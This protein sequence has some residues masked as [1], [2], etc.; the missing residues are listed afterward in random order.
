MQAMSA[1][2]AQ[3]M[4]AGKPERAKKALHIGIGVSEIF[5]VCMFILT[6]TGGRTLCSIFTGRMEVAQAGAD[7]LKAYAIDCLLTS[8]LFCYIGYFDGLEKTHFV[9]IQGLVGAFLIRIPVAFVMSRILP[10]SLFR[11][12]LATPCSSMVQILLCMLYMRQLKEKNR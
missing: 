7:Y 3:N 10:V 9:M 5:A 11:I 2:V 12:G 6:F 4:G 1:F 8:F